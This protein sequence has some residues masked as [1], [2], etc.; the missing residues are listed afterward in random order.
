MVFTVESLPAERP[1]RLRLS[2]LDVEWWRIDEREPS[3]WSW[4]G[5]PVPHNRFDVR[6]A[7]VRYAAR[8]ERGAFREHFAESGRV[9]TP[10][11]ADLWIVRLRGRIRVLDLRHERA[12]DA[13]GLDGEISTSRSARV[14]R[15]CWELSSRAHRW[16]GDDLHGIVY[17]SRTTPQTSANL[18]FFEAAPLSA[19]SVGRLQDRGQLLGQLIVDDGFRVDLPG[20]V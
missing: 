17:T 19:E 11:H 16:Y 2:S 20:W 6:G 7:R 8:T 14:F 4:S 1:G 15:T 12:L 9:L 13:L 18:A 10:R 5:Y 3:A